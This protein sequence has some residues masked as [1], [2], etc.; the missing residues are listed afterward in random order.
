MVEKIIKKVLRKR[1]YWRTVEFDELA[2]LY[3]SQL[4]RTVALSLV[5]VFVSI[6]MYQDGYSLAFIAGFLATQ[7]FAR[8]LFAVPSAHIIGKIGPKHATMMSNIL[9]VP[10]MLSLVNLAEYG[11]YAL[12]V[13]LVFQSISSSLYNIAFHVE[14]SK[15]RHSAHAGKE[16]GYM[17]ILGKV[18]KTVS[19]IIGGFIAFIF[20][21]QTTVFAAAILF[22]C[23]ALPLLRTREPVRTNQKITFQGIK[24]NKIERCLMGEF[25]V[26]W[27]Y[28]NAGIVWSMFVAITIFGTTND[29]VYAKIGLISG[30]SIIAAIISARIYGL[31]IDKKHGNQLLHLGVYG[32][33]LINLARSFI[34]TPIGVV[35]TNIANEA[36]TTAYDMP[37]MKGMFDLADDLPG[38]RIAYMACLDMAIAGGAALCL[39]ALSLLCIAYPEATAMKMIFVLSACIVLLITSH[40]FRALRSRR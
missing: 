3:A 9:Y 14:F 13:S 1:H 7:Y 10:A 37:F 29:S 28:A 18:A 30:L 33:S 8:V 12:T 22:A 35:Y 6:Y 5:S 24:W 11:I 20:G 23:A 2:E 31:I 19:P 34:T 25:G 38:H 17:I 32:T 36:T 39:L 4:L 21:P 15:M 16:I 27:D 26:G 40:D